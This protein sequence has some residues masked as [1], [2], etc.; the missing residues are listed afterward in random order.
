[1]VWG[2][3]GSTTTTEN[4]DTDSVTSMSEN[5]TLQCMSHITTSGTFGVY[6]QYNDDSSGS[7]YHGS[8]KTNGS[9]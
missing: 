6:V 5:D 7:D 3:A 2:K 1:M 8:Y 4:G 9:G